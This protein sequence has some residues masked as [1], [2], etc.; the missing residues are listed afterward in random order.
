M[1]RTWIVDVTMPPTIGSA[2]AC[3]ADSYLSRKTMACVS[4]AGAVAGLCATMGASCVPRCWRCSEE[5]Q[6]PS[7]D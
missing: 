5:P 3:S 6:Q 7:A 2:D 1:K 4:I